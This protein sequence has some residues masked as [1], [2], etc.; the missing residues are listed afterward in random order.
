MI[1]IYL[2]VIYLHFNFILRINNNS[3]KDINNTTSILNKN[4]NSTYVQLI[5]NQ[6]IQK[7]N[8]IY[9]KAKENY[10]SNN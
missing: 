5:K 6:L 9:Q 3:N 4:E 7:D 2:I 10:G 1:I 8:D